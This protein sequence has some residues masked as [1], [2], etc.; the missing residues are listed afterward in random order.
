MLLQWLQARGYWDE[1]AAKLKVRREGGFV[2]VDVVLFLLLF[3]ATGLHRS[4]K[5]FGQ[6]TEPFRKE[7]AA[8]GGRKALATPSSVS[9]YLSAVQSSDARALTQW[10]L[11][12]ACDAN[13]V[14]QHPAAATYDTHGLPWH[15]FDWDGTSTVFRHRA[16]PNGCDLPPPARRSAETGSPGYPTSRPRQRPRAGLELEAA[17][18]IGPAVTPR[19]ARDRRAGLTL[20][21]EGQRHRRRATA[22]A[23]VG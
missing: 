4:L 1:I 10:L 3:L 20:F 23:R 19:A 8:L 9:R 15:V 22:A 2:G 11:I 6:W 7:M 16:L 12:E 5:R 21:R 14:L 13:T 18:T 17:C